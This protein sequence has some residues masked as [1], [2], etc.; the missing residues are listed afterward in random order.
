MYKEREREGER[1]R[2]YANSKHNT[3]HTQT[4]EHTA[5]NAPLVLYLA[6]VRSHHAPMHSLT[7]KGSRHGSLVQPHIGE[8]KEEL[9][10]QVGD[11]NC[12][13]VDDVDVAEAR[14]GEV[15]E[16]FAAQAPGAHDEDL[17]GGQGGQR[18]V[19]AGPEVG[20]KEEGWE[21]CVSAQ[22]SDGRRQ[23]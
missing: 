21:G 10:V 6:R 20:E 14:E 9:P 3:A 22:H 7:D 8:A 11:V 1:E 19:A 13:H 17:G 23:W 12:V 15:F 4:H 2:E 18:R 5:A 16:H